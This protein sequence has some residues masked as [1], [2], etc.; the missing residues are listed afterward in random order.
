MSTYVAVDRTT[1]REVDRLVSGDHDAV[2]FFKS[3]YSDTC[4]I[5]TY[6]GLGTT[7][8]G[9]GTELTLVEKD[10]IVVYGG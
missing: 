5:A 8:I 9:D 4:D 1:R 3:L 7:V 2:E 6:S 10:D